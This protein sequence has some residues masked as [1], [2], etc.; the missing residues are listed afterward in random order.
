MILGV[1]IDIMHTDRMARAIDRGQERLLS[2]LFSPHERGDAEDGPAPCE[3]LAARFA[4]KEAAMKALGTGW[5]GG[6]GW[7][8]F[9]VVREPSGRTLLRMT[10]RAAEIARMLGVTGCHLSLTHQGG[11]AA[12]VVVLEGAG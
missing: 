12:A 8:D 2:R 1:G 11:V 9:E 4:A 7:R 3:R 5:S 10:G 6:V